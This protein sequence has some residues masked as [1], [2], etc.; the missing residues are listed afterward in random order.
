MDSKKFPLPNNESYKQNHKNLTSLKYGCYLT[1]PQTRQFCYFHVLSKA[2]NSTV[3]F[4]S[5][6]EPPR[7]RPQIL[8]SLLIS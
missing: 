1:C 3:S 5:D 7:C 4:T 2:I 6:H 8:S